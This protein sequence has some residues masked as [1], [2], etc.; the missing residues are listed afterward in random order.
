MNW[1]VRTMRSGTSFFNSTLYRKNLARFWPIW[2]VYALIWAFMMPFQFLT[3]PSR[4][5][6][7]SMAETDWLMRQ[8]YQIPELLTEGNFIAFG[9]AVVCAMAV[10]SYLYSARS[11]CTIHALPMDRKNLFFTNYLSGLSFMLLPNL[12]IF[13]FTLGAEALLGCVN[14]QALFTWLWAQSAMCFF[15][16][17][18][19]A[20]CAML[21]G[22]ILALPAF[23]G[24]LSF[25]V[26]V[27][28]SLVSTLLDMFYYGFDTVGDK[29]ESAVLWFTPVARLTMAVNTVRQTTYSDGTTVGW[30][31]HEVSEPE[32]LLI[33]AAV[34]VVLTALAMMVYRRRHVESAGDVVAIPVVRP[35]FR[36]GVAACAGLSLAMG[37]VA[38]LY[39]SN[40]ELALGVFMVIWSVVGY[41]VAEMLLRKSFRVFKAW[42]G[43][44]AIAAVMAL[45]FVAM[46]KDFFGYENRIPARE[47]VKSIYVSSL[48]LGAPS[49]NGCRVYNL[50]VENEKQIMEILSLHQA[51]IQEKDR[52]D[53]GHDYVNL[54]LEYTLKNGTTFSRRYHSVPVYEGETQA[55]DSVTRAAYELSQ[56]RELVRLA[57]GFDEIDDSWRLADVHLEN[58]ITVTSDDLGPDWMYDTV[59]LKKAN[60]EDL[61]RLWQAMLT[62]FDMGRLGVRYLFDSSADRLNNTYTTDLIFQFEKPA[63]T[64]TSG[65][66]NP[67]MVT[68]MPYDADIHYDYDG[69]VEMYQ[70]HISVTL[71]PQARNTL[72]VLEELGFD[73]ARLMTQGELQALRQTREEI[74][75]AL[76]E[77]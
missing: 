31:S 9:G 23:Y 11:A 16:F 28:Y 68:T 60:E 35:V 34:A 6:G 39:F 42:K 29:V 77:K 72:A 52:T 14:L 48:N 57:Y 75:M 63:S 47:D 26:F 46:E 22:N 62:D 30:T 15:Y 69:S 3:L 40:R 10:F 13:L 19:A 74:E 45:L 56:D 18:F 5:L 2:S 66:P 70:R 71:T 41:F 54:T 7:G 25:L 4:Y 65:N 38:V 37:T 58:V 17:S 27:M 12:A 76:W 44:V 59:Y 36:F 43:A 64:D 73:P 67:N 61:E 53:N 49:D 33:Y 21:T 20:F 50:T 32:V 51:I 1:E 24:I 55:V 8:A